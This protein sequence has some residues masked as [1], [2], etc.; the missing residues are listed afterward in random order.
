M[1]HG[2]LSGAIQTTRRRGRAGSVGI[3][4]VSAERDW[5][6][7]EAAVIFL[8]NGFDIGALFSG[9]RIV[10]LGRIAIEFGGADDG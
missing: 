1:I 3:E 8:A 10:A 4:V 7:L 6:V 2:Y 5:H 9:C